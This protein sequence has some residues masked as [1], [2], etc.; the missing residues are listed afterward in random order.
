MNELRNCS[1]CARLVAFREQQRAK[2]PDYHNRP[3]AAFGDNNARL[4]IIGLAPGL[5]GANASGRPFS[6]DSSGD[7]LFGE[8]SRHGFAS[9]AKS[10]DTDGLGLIGC[11]ITNAV[12][13]VP[14]QNRPLSAEIHACGR[15]L[16]AEIADLP[17]G[18]VML[19]L[20][21]IAHRAVLRALSLKLSHYGFHHG[22]EYLLPGGLRLIDCYHPS[23]YNQNT[24]RINA[25]MLSDVLDSVSA[26][27]NE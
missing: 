14:P 17:G 25:A 1:R 20:G 4:L 26:A 22:E 15:Y 3:V 5:H 9:T 13:C 7:L 21:A 10:R 24:G 6:G 27:L 12:K 11:R 19:A 23:L 16:R 8:L 2:Y 18:S